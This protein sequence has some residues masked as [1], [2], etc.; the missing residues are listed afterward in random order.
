MSSIKKNLK[1][2]LVAGLCAVGL[3]A[4]GKKLGVPG[5]IADKAQTVE[6][7][8]TPIPF[9]RAYA[10]LAAKQLKPLYDAIAAKIASTGHFNKILD[11]GS[12][13]GYLPIE[14]SKISPDSCIYGVD[15][16]SN[17]VRL[18]NAATLGTRANKCV[19]FSSGG[20]DNLPFPGR[21]FDLAVSVN[22]LHHWKNPVA[23][24]DEVFHTLLPEGQFWIYDYRNDVP[25]DLWNAMREK[26]PVHLRTMLLFGPIASSRAAYSDEDIRKFVRQTHFEELGIEKI[27]LPLFGH[28]TPAFNLIKLAKPIQVKE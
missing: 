2:G 15:E 19:E 13:L 8:P 27:S 6:K 17:L 18:A 4:L 9:T 25:E 26:L 1:T 24:L 28:D 7:I 22:V 10:V 5:R 3:C 12:G 14:L 21:Y 11:L 23:V 20:Y 16:S